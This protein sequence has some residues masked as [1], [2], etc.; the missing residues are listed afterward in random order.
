MGEREE[1]IAEA[2]LAADDEQAWRATRD[3]DLG[4][5]AGWVSRREMVE[6]CAADRAAVEA[7]WAERH[8]RERRDYERGW[9]RWV[10]QLALDREAEREAGEAAA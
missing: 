5:E 1:Y 10:A 8:D 9:W 6:S 3:I 7:D 4:H 2:L